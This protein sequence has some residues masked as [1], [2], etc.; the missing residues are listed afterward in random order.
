M[1]T[2]T[3]YELDEVGVMAPEPAPGGSLHAGGK[4][5]YLSA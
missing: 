3:S 2:K 5:G 4:G 1:A